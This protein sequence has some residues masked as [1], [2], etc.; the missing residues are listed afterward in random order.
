M[1]SN[2]ET[3]QKSKRGGKRSG[4]GRPR[5][6]P[7]EVMQHLTVSVSARTLRI[8]SVLGM[9]DGKVNMSEG[10]RRSAEVAYDRYQK[11]YDK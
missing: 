8:L 4:A 7:D 1:I 2:M 10:V 3:K 9:I 6:N 11:T 5:T